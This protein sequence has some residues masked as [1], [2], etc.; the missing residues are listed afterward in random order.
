MTKTMLKVLLAAVLFC[1]TA[2]AD[3]DMGQGGYTACDGNNPP[4]TCECTVPEPPTTCNTGGFAVESS[5]DAADVDLT[6]IVTEIIE[7]VISVV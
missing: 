3:G 6:M 7:T 2:I 4:P 1:G 5:S